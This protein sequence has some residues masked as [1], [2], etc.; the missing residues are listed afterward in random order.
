MF[1]MV[2]MVVCSYAPTYLFLHIGSIPELFH[3]LA[4]IE[5]IGAD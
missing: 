5:M 1:Y 2:T 3:R 4:V